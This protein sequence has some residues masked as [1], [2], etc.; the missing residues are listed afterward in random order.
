MPQLNSAAAFENP[1]VDPM[2]VTI[3]GSPERC[4]ERIHALSEAGVWHFVLEFQFHG[5]EDAAFGMKQME[6]FVKE[7]GP[8]L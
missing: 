4:A 7:V 5:Q 2:N 6:K 1:D 3:S 8:L